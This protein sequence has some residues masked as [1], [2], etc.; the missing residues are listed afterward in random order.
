LIMYKVTSGGE[1][2]GYSEYESTIDG[3]SWSP[4]VYPAGWT[5]VSD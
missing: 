4:E 2:I 1:V 3:N 5:L